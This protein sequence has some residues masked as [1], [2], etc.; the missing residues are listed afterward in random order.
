MNNPQNNKILFDEVPASNDIVFCTKTG[1]TAK[2]MNV[3]NN[4]IYCISVTEGSLTKTRILKIFP[5]A[6]MHI[7]DAMMS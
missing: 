1:L 2:T 3:D 5:V 4:I 7:V 6:S